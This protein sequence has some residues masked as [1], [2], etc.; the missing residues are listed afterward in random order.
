LDA[1][2]AAQRR[3]FDENAGGTAGKEVEGPQWLEG[4]VTPPRGIARDLCTDVH[5]AAGEEI[6]CPANIGVGTRGAL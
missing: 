4:T 2:L 3:L 6:A 1:T 5:L